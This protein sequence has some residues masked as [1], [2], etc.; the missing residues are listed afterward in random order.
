MALFCTFPK[1]VMFQMQ[2]KIWKVKLLKFVQNK[3]SSCRCAADLP[4]P[5]VTTGRSTSP[6]DIWNTCGKQRGSSTSG[7]GQ[8]PGGPAGGGGPGEEM[9]AGVSVGVGVWA[10]SGGEEGAGTGAG[11]RAGAGAGE[12]APWPK[13]LSPGLMGWCCACPDMIEKKTVR[14]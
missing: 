10:G 11:E 9:A 1:S 6:C 7:A 4:I 12:G 8:V 13:L 2:K 3:L 5:L 14:Q